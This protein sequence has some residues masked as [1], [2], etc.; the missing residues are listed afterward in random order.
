MKV[1]NQCGIEKML[2][3]FYKQKTCKDGYRPDCKECVKARAKA[4]RED[5][6]EKVKIAKQRYY[7]ENPNYN[8]DYMRRYY[9]DN[10]ADI[11][12]KQRLYIT[13]NRDKRRTYDREYRE[14]NKEKLR[15]RASKYYFENPEIFKN[16]R[17]KRRSKMKEVE[18]TLTSKELKYVNEVFENRCALSGECIEHYDH[19]IPIHLGIEGTTLKNIIPMTAKLNLSKGGK[20]PFEWVKQRNDIDED[21]FRHVVLYLADLNNMT[22]KEYESHVYACFETTSKTQSRRKIK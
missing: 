9:E 15:I 13:E 8:R 6:P 19:F 2:T 18:H 11:L 17:L 7:E 12:E 10:K 22:P 4:Y 1:C 5:N 14:A 21:R 20:N 16:G 3:S